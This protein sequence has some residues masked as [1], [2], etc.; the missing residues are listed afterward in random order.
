MVASLIILVIAL[1]GF[2]NA[3]V[4]LNYT[5]CGTS[6]SSWKPNSVYVDSPPVKGQ[7]DT[8]HLVI[9]ISLIYLISTF[10]VV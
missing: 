5:D 10:S 2:T 6:G 9:E 7:S 4:D 8:I 1:L 3:T